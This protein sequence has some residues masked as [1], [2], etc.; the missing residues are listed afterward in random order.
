[1]SKWEFNKAPGF[2][3]GSMAA[4]AVVMCI[5]C[6]SN[7]QPDEDCFDREVEENTIF[8][9]KSCWKGTSA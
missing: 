1:M 8:L 9:C 5:C 7:I 4:P 6:G 2:G 3:T